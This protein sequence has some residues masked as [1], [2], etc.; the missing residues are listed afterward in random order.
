MQNLP[1]ELIVLLPI[2]INVIMAGIHANMIKEGKKIKHGLWGGGYLIGL[3]ALCFAYDW[4]G[5][6]WWLL[7]D[8][9]LIRKVFFDIP[10]NL[11]R[12]L[13]F[14][15]V[16]STTTSIIDRF[17]NSVFGKHSEIYMTIYFLASIY[18][19]VWQL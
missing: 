9:L 12:G 2:A 10:L 11:F 5:F 14:F 1:K 4:G 7:L 3:V 18:I 13:P 19:T 15:Y 16:S 8:G 17:H 6:N